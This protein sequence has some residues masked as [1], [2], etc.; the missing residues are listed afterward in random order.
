MGS[1]EYM[2]KKEADALRRDRA[3]LQKLRDA[4][5]EFQQIASLVGEPNAWQMVSRERVRAI[6]ERHGLDKP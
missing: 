1:T 3:E 5:R 6:L 2:T 4:V